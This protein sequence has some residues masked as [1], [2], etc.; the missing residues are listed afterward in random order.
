[1]A[2][3]DYIDLRTAV[4]EE[5][6]SADIADVMDR[7]TKLAEA[8]LNRK[9]RTRHQITEATLTFMDG[10]AD[11]PADFAEIIGLY[12]AQGCEYIAQPYQVTARTYPKPYYAV[13]ASQIVGPE[14]ELTLHYYAKLPTLTASMT[15]SNWLL[16]NYP[17][18]YLYAVSL[19]AAKH[20]R[21][22]D[23][24]TALDAMFKAELVDLISDD[25]SARYARARVRVMGPT[26]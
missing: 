26:P 1:M 11:L 10:V 6:G 7:L 5:V 4:I 16:E 24:A 3:T 8:G 15:T 13:N 22:A 17:S 21:D 19:E 18:V 25:T 20:M 9:L 2:F 14:G 23:Q 12:D